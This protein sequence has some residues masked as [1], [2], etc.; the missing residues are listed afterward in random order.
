MTPQALVMATRKNDLGTF[1]LALQDVE[2]NTTLHPKQ[3]RDW[4]HCIIDEALAYVRD[5]SRY[6]KNCGYLPN[7]DPPNP[8]TL[9]SDEGSY[10]RREQLYFPFKRHQLIQFLWD[11]Y[12]RTRR[13]RGALLSSEER[14]IAGREFLSWRGV[15]WWRVQHW[16]PSSF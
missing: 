1:I 2:Q 12:H 16:F 13:P 14:L 11:V 5:T 6:D 4:S 10:L 15:K 7:L 3:K 9:L 8:S